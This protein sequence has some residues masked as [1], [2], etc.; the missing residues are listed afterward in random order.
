MPKM[1]NVE[2]ARPYAS[3][4]DGRDLIEPIEQYG[5]K[6]LSI[7]FFV[8]A[9][10]ATLWRGSMASNTLKQLIADAD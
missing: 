9:E 7:G 10:T 3:K 8:N 1:F 5:V 2:N 6:L 4:V